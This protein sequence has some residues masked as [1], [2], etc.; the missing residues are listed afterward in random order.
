MSSNLVC[1]NCKHWDKCK[2]D[3]AVGVCELCGQ[4]RF[5]FEQ[6]FRWEFGEQRQRYDESKEAKEKKAKE[7]ED[8]IVSLIL[9]GRNAKYISESLKCGRE[10][11][12]ST[13]NKYGLVI[14]KMQSRPGTRKVSK[15]MLEKINKLR[16][17]GVSYFKISR[18][19][20]IGRAALMGAV[21]REKQAETE[22]EINRNRLATI[23]MERD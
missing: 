4:Y 15:E 19:L 22:L 1:L 2:D 12:V 14:N 10:L 13:A 3:D 18:D 20:G 11:V 17:D 5:Q 8:N 9:E 7:K 6:C 23:K 16:A 21:K